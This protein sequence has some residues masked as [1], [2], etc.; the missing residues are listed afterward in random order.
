MNRLFKL[1]IQWWG[2][3]IHKT[4]YLPLTQYKYIICKDAYKQKTM[5][6]HAQSL[7]GFL[8][9]HTWGRK[10]TDLYKHIIIVYSEFISYIYVQLNLKTI[11]VIYP[12]N[13]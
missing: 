5:S 1:Q 4:L 10:S 2:H 13:L 9:I 6:V 3:V 8:S 7:Q 11:L 12:L